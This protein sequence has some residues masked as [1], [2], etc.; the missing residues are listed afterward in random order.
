MPPHADHLSALGSVV[1]LSTFSIMIEVV[2]RWTRLGVADVS[3][4]VAKSVGAAAGTAIGG[5]M[6]RHARTPAAH[7]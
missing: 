6:L 7:T 3:D 1:L 4:L 5:V 2:Q